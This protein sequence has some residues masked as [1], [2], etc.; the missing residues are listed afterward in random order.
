M[1][2]LRR[3]D[4]KEA[5][6]EGSCLILLSF[7]TEKGDR[8]TVLSE[9]AIVRYADEAIGEDTDGGAGKTKK[10]PEQES[11]IGAPGKRYQKKHTKGRRR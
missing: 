4:R 2:G 1:E 8:E 9:S 5:R 3:A 11:F 7:K 10:K 6:E